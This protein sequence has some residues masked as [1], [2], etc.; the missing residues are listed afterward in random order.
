MEPRARHE[1]ATL[2]MSHSTIARAGAPEIL[3]LG[4]VRDLGALRAEWNA[5]AARVPGS[6]YFQTGDWVIAWWVT[7]GARAATRVACW[8]DGDGRLRA[9]AAV[10]DGHE[11]LHRRLG[12][13]VPV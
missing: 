8:R 11:I 10:S 1:G 3:S 13:R 6:S 7:V 5:L 2:G 12:L 4:N 9:L